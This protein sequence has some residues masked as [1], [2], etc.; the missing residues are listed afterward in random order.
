M[1]IAQIWSHNNV[2]YSRNIQF[3]RPS[4]PGDFRTLIL[5]SRRRDYEVVWHRVT[6]KLRR[7]ANTLSQR[8]PTLINSLT[9]FVERYLYKRI[10]FHVRVEE[11]RASFT[12]SVT[13]SPSTTRNQSSTTSQR[14]NI[15]DAG[16]TLWTT[17]YQ[18]HVHKPSPPGTSRC[19]VLS[20]Y[21]VHCSF[22]T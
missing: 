15:G 21:L 17:S 5:Y 10:N 1:N 11:W 13:A 9:Y 6:A 3:G 7:L 12:E 8:S 18:Q 4:G 20:V 2:A 14:N 19:S 22:F 16:Q